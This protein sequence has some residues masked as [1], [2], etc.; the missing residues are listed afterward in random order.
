MDHQARFDDR[1]WVKVVDAARK[2]T[3]LAGEFSA[4][5][6]LAWS[7]NGATVFFAASN[8]QASDESRPDFSYQ[9]RAVALDRPGTSASALTNPGNF[10]IH[11]IAPDGR[12]LA[13]RKT[14]ALASVRIWLAMRPTVIS[15]G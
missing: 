13:T 6:G 10:T 7:R 9:V 15:R 4:E 3:T 1:G 8:Q 2:V 11:D 5:Q 14:R 12:W